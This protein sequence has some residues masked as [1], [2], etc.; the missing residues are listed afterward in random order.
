MPASP[1]H[2]VVLP[3]ALLDAARAAA[4]QPGARPGD[5]VRLAL[6]QMAGVDVRDHP[7][8]RG[9]PKRRRR[10]QAGGTAV[11]GEGTAA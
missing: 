11:R 9:R 10:T 1:R 8:K 5:I 4:G 6:A 7:V 3:P 2:N